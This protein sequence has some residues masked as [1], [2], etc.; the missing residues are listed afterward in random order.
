MEPHSGF[1]LN[2]LWHR[3]L[4]IVAELKYNIITVLLNS[5]CCLK[6]FEALSKEHLLLLHCC[7]IITLYFCIIH[8]VHVA[9][10]RMAA[11]TTWQARSVFKPLIRL[12]M[13]H[14]PHRSNP[15]LTASIKSGSLRRE[16]NG[17][18]LEYSVCIQ[19]FIIQGPHPE[20][21]F[22]WIELLNVFDIFA[23]P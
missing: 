11:C 21:G 1:L 4:V 23:L 2:C 13:G 17:I 15:A 8:T 10:F 22:D 14:Q 3:L 7:D 5:I 16:Y 18:N 19:I 12:T 9:I 6:P 20:E